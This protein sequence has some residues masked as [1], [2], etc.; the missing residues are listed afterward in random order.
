[1]LIFLSNRSDLVSN[2]DPGR[3]ALHSHPD[4]QRYHVLASCE[5]PY[6]ALQW[7]G[8]PYGALSWFWNRESKVL[9]VL[10]GGWGGRRHTW[11]NH[12]PSRLPELF[13]KLD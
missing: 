6:Y 8:V 11:A 2:P 13:K 10:D 12:G 1:M 3:R 9:I 5:V 7:C 4:P